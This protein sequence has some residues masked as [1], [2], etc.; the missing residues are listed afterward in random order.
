MPTLYFGGSFNPIHDGH[1]V[2]S[3]A[4]AE[5]AGFEQVVLMPSGQA[6]HKPNAANMAEG[7]HRLVMCQLAVAGDP[8][9]RVSDLEIAR[10]GPSYTID[11]VRRLKERC[12]EP[13][14]WLIG[15]DMLLYLQYW[16]EPEKLLREVN[17]VIMARPGW[18]LD[19]QLLPAEHRLL[20]QNVIETPLLD[21]SST[22]IRARVA[23]AKAI[24]YL[25]PPAVCRYIR[26]QG[27]YL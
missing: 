26:E 18:T 25:T 24:D 21:I 22:D 5:R 4:V 6:P 2:C 7:R 11:T 27:L 15:A 10:D 9:F 20:Q 13:I 12:E 1:L 16:H 23:A 17:F 3:R 14:H 19:W 8:M